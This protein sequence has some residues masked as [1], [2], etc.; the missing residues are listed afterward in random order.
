MARQLARK[1][2][3]NSFVG[4]TSAAP[5]TA[6]V[7]EQLLE[8]GDVTLAMGRFAPSEG[9]HVRFPKVT[10]A[11]HNG[12]P[13][14][15]D[16]RAP[17]S[18]RTKSPI[19]R[20]GQAMLSD[21]GVPVWKRW[22]EPR[23]IFAFTINAAFVARISEQI[24][25]GAGHETIDAR[26]GL[27]DLIIGRLISL[28]WRELENDG[29]S[30]RLY[31]EGLA[32]SLAVHLLRNYGISRRNAR[33]SKGG[34]SPRQLRR[35]VEYIDEHLD[36]ELALAEL[37]SVAGLSPHHFGE[38]FKISMGQP[39]H[40]YVMGKRVTRAREMLRNHELPIS[41]VAYALG[42]AS[43]SHFTTQFGR[44]T[45]ITPGRFRRSLR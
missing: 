28:G 26:V 18:D 24:F 38:A 29:A 4:F 6:F 39:P 45:G 12:A 1:D 23:S 40:R 20:H 37:A 44:V 31:A 3:K 43:Q 14:N 11:V 15:L 10:L 7:C 42:F 30:G 36:R 34:L 2:P 25:D 8:I 16:W 17:E 35:V 27:N 9:D 32:S 41:E 22:I 5:S 19:L 13:L 33:L 21:A